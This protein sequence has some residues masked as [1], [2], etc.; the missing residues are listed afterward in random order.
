MK[1][2]LSRAYLR[3][4]R[5]Y[6]ARSYAFFTSMSFEHV[7]GQALRAWRPDVIHA[8]DG[9]TL[10]TAA[11]AARELG[12]RLVFDSH[13]LESYR[14]P[15]LSRLRRLQ[16]VWEER[17]YLPQADKVI[18][19]TN[20]IADYL[21]REYEIERP[22][23]I[24]NAPPASSTRTAD[25]WEVADRWDV[26]SDL[27][28]SPRHFLFCYTGNVTLNRGLELAVIAL[29][30]IQG[31]HDPNE[32]FGSVY[33]LA[34]VGQATE[35]HIEPLERL[36]EQN[37]VPIHFLPPVAPHRVAEYIST[38]DASIIPILPIT[39]SYEYAM[40]NKL[41]EAMLAGNPII[42]ADLMEM[43]SFIEEH[44]LGLTYAADDP[45]D[46]AAKMLDLLNDV[47]RF[48]RSPARQR[49]LAEQFAWE[50][51]ERQLLDLYDAM[52]GKS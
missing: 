25:R 37:S 5:P 36:A 4:I 38:A 8:H 18:T 40:P 24:Y 44:G 31:Y 2:A 34:V 33:S 26:R 43:G 49:E 46:C 15:P 50:A 47:P 42:G 28:L 10:P 48:Q 20:R 32:R 14:N 52:L 6:L 39:L 22:T 35:R 12:A 23:V 11:K 51:Q 16:V 29:G 17:R 41:F 21:A 30:R 45:E 3:L 1:Q 27:R 9:V 13:E 19:V 7:F